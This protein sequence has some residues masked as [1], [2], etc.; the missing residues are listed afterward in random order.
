MIGRDSQYQHMRA[1][2]ICQWAHHLPVPVI[3]RLRCRSV[4]EDTGLRPHDYA[5]YDPVFIGAY[6][7]AQQSV[8][9]SQLWVAIDFCVFGHGRYPRWRA[10]TMRKSKQARGKI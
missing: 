4:L 8:K 1:P 3:C 10:N 2:V 6:Y 5:S 9:A 7:D